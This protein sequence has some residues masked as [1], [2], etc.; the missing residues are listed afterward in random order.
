[1]SNLNRRGSILILTALGSLFIL[2]I[3]ALVT[4]IGFAYFQK[5]RL[6]T[7]VDNAWRA[8]F[9]EYSL[10]RLERGAASPPVTLSTA[11]QERIRA[12]V[13][14][15]FQSNGYSAS[16]AAELT[17]GLPGRATA[18]SSGRLVVSSRQSFGLFFARVMNFEQM[19]VGASRG[20]RVLAT[21]TF[22]DGRCS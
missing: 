10:V 1:M 15:I 19:T 14:S 17:I 20:D 8:G 7:A 22:D 12:R 16:E 11:D 6:Q 2:G 9:D 13:R 18:S 3:C 5:N 4:D 21:D